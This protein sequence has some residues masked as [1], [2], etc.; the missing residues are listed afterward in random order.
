MKENTRLR[1][2]VEAL[3]RRGDASG[4]MAFSDGESGFC[5]A[6]GWADQRASRP[7]TPE[8]R[9]CLSLQG[10]FP[11]AMAALLLI[12]EKRLGFNDSVSRY[13]PEYPGGDRITIRQLLSSGSGV[14]DLAASVSAAREHDPAYRALSPAKRI[15]RE[16]EAAARGWSETEALP[17]LGKLPADF[18]PGS[19]KNEY[20]PSNALLLCFIAQRAASQSLFD[21]LNQRL[22]LPLG[23]RPGRATIP[24]A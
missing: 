21:I 3:A 14:P 20:S 6:F 22:F 10:Q 23:W 4:A 1:Q 12:Q 5:C 19:R 16:R 15:K 18:P 8:Q 2:T 7:M 17:L 13:L 11:A 9:F 24:T